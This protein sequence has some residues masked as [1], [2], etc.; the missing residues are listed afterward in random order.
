MPRPVLKLVDPGG[1][2]GLD[3]EPPSLKPRD[4][5]RV[6]PHLP[7][8]LTTFFP[9]AAKWHPPAHRSPGSSQVGPSTRT[10]A[11]RQSFHLGPSSPGARGTLPLRLPGWFQ[12][13]VA[14]RGVGGCRETRS[15]G[16]TRG[17]V[18]GQLIWDALSGAG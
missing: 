12:D 16:R 13:R 4:V 10:R 7:S 8:R 1:D 15:A 14:K 11:P 9:A 6:P 2:P 18:D 5:F 3:Q 17:D